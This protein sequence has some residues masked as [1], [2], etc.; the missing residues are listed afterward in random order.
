MWTKQITFLEKNS[1]LAIMNINTIYPVREEELESHSTLCWCGYFFPWMMSQVN[2]RLPFSLVLHLSL[3]KLPGELVKGV[4]SVHQTRNA[5]RHTQHT[6]LIWSIYPIKARGGAIYF[7]TLKVSEGENISVHD[8]VCAFIYIYT[9]CSDISQCFYCWAV[10]APS[11]VYLLTSVKEGRA[12]RWQ[13][14]M[15]HQACRHSHRYSEQPQPCRWC[16]CFPV[17][18]CGN[19]KSLLTVW[20]PT[21]DI[22]RWELSAVV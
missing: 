1:Q 15:G 16:A 7:S 13:G 11:R 5:Q 10:S 20:N 17:C 8:N 14:G 6:V 12:L 18:G 3:T 21:E 9:N 19:A 4:Q 2:L 22:Y